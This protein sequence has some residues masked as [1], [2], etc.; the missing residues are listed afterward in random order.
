[1]AMNFHIGHLNPLKTHSERITKADKTVINNL[2]FEG[3]DFPV[4]KKYYCKIEQ[5][6]NIYTNDFYKNDLTCLVYV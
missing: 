1:M 5:K 2:D 3:I 6:N 4:F